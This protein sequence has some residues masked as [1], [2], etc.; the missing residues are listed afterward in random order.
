M[1]LVLQNPPI[2]EL[3]IATYFNPHL[4]GLRSEHIGLFWSRIREEFPEAKQRVP[5]GGLE[6]FGAVAEGVFPMPRYWFYSR[7]RDYSIQIQGNGI[8]L[9]WKRGESGYPHFQ[10]TLKGAFDKYYR[11]F[12]DFVIEEGVADGLSIN[13]C[14]LLYANSIEQCEY[15]NGPEDLRKVFEDDVLLDIGVGDRSSLTFDCRYAQNVSEHLSLHVSVRSARR[16]TR[17]ANRALLFEIRGVGRLVGQG[18]SAADQWF[19][20]A[21]DAIV[22]CFLN[23]T[24]K[25]IQHSY[26]M[27]N[28]RE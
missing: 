8:M 7:N 4:A 25:D 1:K 17:Q 19:E 6:A 3:V 27:S 16:A 28:R 10:E 2:R 13:S 23:I 21:H 14:E 12:E 18:K 11:A 9:N 24:R 22:Q 26:W 5:Q 15:W 20:D